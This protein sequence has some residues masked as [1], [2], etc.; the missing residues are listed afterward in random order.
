MTPTVT[1]RKAGWTAA[2]P[3][4]ETGKRR[5]VVVESEQEG[6][7]LIQ[8]ETKAAAIKRDTDLSNEEASR[9]SVEYRSVLSEWN[10]ELEK[11]R[12]VDVNLSR[13]SIKRK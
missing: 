5:Q 7:D 6:W 11:L 2:F 13:K 8:R 3:H 1:L 10:D 12:S 9:L 4:P